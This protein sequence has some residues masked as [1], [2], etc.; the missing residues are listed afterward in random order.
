MVN[1][2]CK[3]ME[4]GGKMLTLVK[5]SCNSPEFESLILCQRS[6]FF[7]RRMSIFT[8]SLLIVNGEEV[9]VPL[10]GW[11]EMLTSFVLC[12]KTNLISRLILQ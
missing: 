4:Y 11:I 12:G 5:E 9:K 8:F 7:E 2:V 3:A 1:K 10:C 6:T